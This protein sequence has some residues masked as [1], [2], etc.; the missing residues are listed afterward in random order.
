MQSD[1]SP[2]P[3]ALIGARTVARGPTVLSAVV[4]QQPSKEVPRKQGRRLK[5]GD[6]GTTGRRSALRAMTWWRYHRKRIGLAILLASPV[7]LGFAGQQYFYHRQKAV[8]PLA[9]HPVGPRPTFPLVG[10]STG[11]ASASA[12]ALKGPVISGAIVQAHAST[13]ADAASDGGPAAS[14]LQAAPSRS[15]A[16]Y[17]PAKFLPAPQTPAGTATPVALPPA[18]GDAAAV[19][20]PLPLPALLPSASRGGAVQKTPMGEDS[21][22]VKVTLKMPVGPSKPAT[23]KVGDAGP[24]GQPEKAA[25]AATEVARPQAQSSTSQTS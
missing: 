1:L 4:G 18:V 23:P 20:L 5:R 2:N 11:G 16:G 6:A 15:T 9:V 8:A 3:I 25:N 19:P 17:E 7:L 10:T 24:V 21:A 13:D 22:G 14:Q 12:P